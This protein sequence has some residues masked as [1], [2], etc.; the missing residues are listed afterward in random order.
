MRNVIKLIIAA[1]II[2]GNPIF[3][4]AAGEAISKLESIEVSE[5]AIFMVLTND[6][7]Y[8]V[9]NLTNPQRMVVDFIDTQYS[10]KNNIMPV[11]NHFVKRIRGAQH[12]KNPIQ[13]ARIVID[14]NIPNV[15]FEMTREGN[16]IVME[17]FESENKSNDN[18]QGGQTR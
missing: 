7:E 16:I 17:L 4:P 9:F 2:F 18:H 6:T 15:E 14:L 11:N 8:D 12:K 10:L 13:I 1:T 5:N 3:L